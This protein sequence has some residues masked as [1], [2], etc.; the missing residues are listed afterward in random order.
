[1]CRYVK[2]VRPSRSRPYSSA[3]GSFTLS[4]SSAE[5]QTSSTARDPRADGDVGLVG[6]ARPD[7]R[8]PPRRSPR[9]RAAT[10]SSAPAGVSA[11]RYSRCLISLATPIRIAAARY[12]NRRSTQAVRRARERRRHV[13]AAGAAQAAAREPLDEPALVGAEQRRPLPRP[14]SRPPARAATSRRD[15]EVDPRVGE[16]PLQERLRP[17]LDPEG[18]QRLEERRLRGRRR[19][20]RAAAPPS[21]RI[22]ITAMPSSSASGRIRALALALERVERDLDR[23]EPPGPQRLLELVEL[24]PR[25]SA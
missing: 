11:T 18:P 5:P 7:A 4:S 12:R 23:V 2:S 9:G 19:S 15:H 3:I 6:E 1:M 17:R 14:R 13:A 10:S 21:G 20:V 25:P 22:T 8:R 16:A 24:R